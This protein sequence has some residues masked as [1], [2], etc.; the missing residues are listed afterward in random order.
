MSA[1]DPRQEYV[2]AL[3][4]HTNRDRSVIAFDCGSG[5]FAGPW[6][7]RP[8]SLVRAESPALMLALA[9]GAASA[10]RRALCHGP[11][12]PLAAAAAAALGSVIGAPPA[13][14]L[15]GVAPCEPPEPPCDLAP[16][17]A[18]SAI[19]VL[20]PA[21]GPQAAAAADTLVGIDGLVYMRLPAGLLPDVTRP[22]ETFEPDALLPLREG[23]DLCIFA[24]GAAAAP[25][26]RAADQLLGQGLFASVV[27]APALRPLDG[28]EIVR[29]TRRSGRALTAEEHGPGGLGDAVCRALRG[30]P[31]AVDTV[32]LPAGPPAVAEGARRTAADEIFLRAL[33]LLAW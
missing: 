20:C 2:R 7:G 12:G 15:V 1:H 29:W 25:A 6:A 19:R 30:Q 3:A 27:L 18:L 5:L 10:R 23:R 33:A 9:A 4:R 11:C 8:G 17:G 24:A 14:A 28:E 16:L 13:V 32:Y 22:G 26:L 31:V 21:D